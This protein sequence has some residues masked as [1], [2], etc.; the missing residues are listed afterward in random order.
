MEHAS[1]FELLAPGNS[2]LAVNLLE[3]LSQSFGLFLTLNIGYKL[4]YSSIFLRDLNGSR[5]SII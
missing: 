4:N 2:L 1:F 3:Q 5:S